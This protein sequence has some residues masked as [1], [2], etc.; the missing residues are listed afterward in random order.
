MKKLFFSVTLIF[1]FS[2]VFAASFT[3][4]PEFKDVFTARE[5]AIGENYISDTDSYFSFL[6]NPASAGLVGNRKIFPFVSF[7]MEKDFAGLSNLI[8][9]VSSASDAE[10]ANYLNNMGNIK[11]KLTMTGP[12]CFGGVTNNFAWGIFNSTYTSTDLY[13]TATS[14][15]NFGEQFL[16]NV[17]YAYPIKFG[18]SAL[19]IGLSVKG[20]VDVQGDYEGAISSAIN[21][22][23][24]LDFSFFPF[25]T[26][27]ALGLD[28]GITLSVCNILIMSFAWNNFFASSIS[29]KFDNAEKFK[30]FSFD[31]EPFSKTDFPSNL[32]SAVAI[33]IPL[34]KSTRGFLT[35]TNLY[36]QYGDL[37]NVFK[38]IKEKTPYD[39][40]SPMATGCELEIFHTIVFRYG[41]NNTYMGGGLGL[42]LEIVHIDI[43][44]YTDK[45]SFK[46]NPNGD[47]GVSLS[48]GIYK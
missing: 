48:F 15:V 17:G 7:N 21:N 28:A 32:K 9:T 36:F 16:L 44:F 31:Y 11:T 25:Y 23:K 13:G 3:F 43:T 27:A 12:V 42:N 14:K 4:N 2:F 22:I 33:K 18:T 41:V 38:S 30:T 24:K 5:I 19:S 34:E 29:Q 35:K 37:I 47:F 20:L 45:V 10:I 40:L 26:T 1:F 39:Y 6:Q 46:V 8:K